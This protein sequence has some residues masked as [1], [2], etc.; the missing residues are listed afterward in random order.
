[1]DF[2]PGRTADMQ[3]K[4]CLQIIKISTTEKDIDGQEERKD[5]CF[6]NGCKSNLCS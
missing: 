5:V 1:M 6:R 2:E 4:L 3:F